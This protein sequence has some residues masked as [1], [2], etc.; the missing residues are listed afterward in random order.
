[1]SLRRLT[2]ALL[3][4]LALPALASAA[5]PGGRLLAEARAALPR[6]WTLQRT[7]LPEGLVAVALGPVTPEG[8]PVVALRPWTL[9]DLPDEP[10]A[11]EDLGARLA[12]GTPLTRVARGPL[13]WEVEAAPTGGLV[14]LYVLH[15]RALVTI[16]APQA[17]LAA[18]YRQV[19]KAAA[20]LE[21]ALAGG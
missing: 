8:R 15:P 9:P 10:G 14:T 11:A 12:P 16:T 19:L 21:G 3:G 20:A 5:D 2:G 18:T 17:R 6:G 13:G 7:G 1:V 4:V